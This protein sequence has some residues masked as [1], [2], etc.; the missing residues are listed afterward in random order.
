MN[1]RTVAWWRPVWRGAAVCALLACGG[2]VEP[3]TSAPGIVSVRV[4]PRASLIVGVGG[5][6]TFTA[7]IRTR[8]GATSPGPPQWSVEDPDVAVIAPGA[9]DRAVVT[10]VAS[11]ATRVVATVDGVRGGARLEVYVPEEV[12]RFEP[13]R[14][15]YGRNR[16]TEYIPG[17]LPVI[18]SAPHGGLLRPSEMPD[19]RAGVHLNDL[20]S[21]ELTLA[22]RDALLNLTGRAPHVIINHLHRTKL[23]ANRDIEE[24]AEGDPFAEQAWREFHAWTGTARD[25]VAAESGAGLYLDIHGHGHDIPRIELGYLLNHDDL[26][27]ADGALDGA[28]VVGRSSIRALGMASPLPFSQLLRGSNSFGGLLEAEGI[29]SVPSPADPSPG[30]TPYFRGGYNT[31]A[32]GSLL[33]DEVISG[34]QLEHQLPG[35]RDTN[36]NRRA[37]ADRAAR[38]IQRFMQEHYG[39]LGTMIAAD[40]ATRGGGSTRQP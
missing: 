12:D 32:Y 38:V 15:Y 37:Y 17:E 5:E 28:G 2:A 36:A 9:S 13:G 23:D 31:R 22:M 25:T 8:A 26:N 4:A 20:N 39:E 7:V 34:I 21:R 33:R 16:Y 35:L 18:L 10:G 1:G 6:T 11:G 27:R 3:D 19:R 29:P 14:S 40:P 24:A 30:T